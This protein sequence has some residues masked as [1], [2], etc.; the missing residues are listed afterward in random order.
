MADVTIVIPVGPGH[1]DLANRAISSAQGQTVPVE[2]L[3]VEDNAGRGPGWARNRGLAET[4]TKWVVFL[5]ADDYLEPNAI[6]RL[7]AMAA[8]HPGRYVYSDAWMGDAVREAPETGQA[9]CKGTWH[10]VTALLPAQ[11]VKWVGGFD[12]TLPGGED[13]E[14]YVKL[15][16]SGLCGVRVPEPLVH[17]TPAGQRSQAFRNGPRYSETMRRIYERWSGKMACCGN[18]DTQLN[19]AEGDRQPGDVL[20]QTLWMGNRP[21]RGIASGR[22]YGRTG[23]GKL[24]WMDPRDIE[25]QPHLFRRVENADGVPEQ[26]NAPRSSPPALPQFMRE[27][28]RKIPVAHGIDQIGAAIFGTRVASQKPQHYRPMRPVEQVDV[29]D[30]IRM[31]LE[32]LE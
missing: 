26:L 3:V 9:W 28:A 32:A 6:E 10:V 20:A 21:A 31:G 4:Q 14:L 2:V 18:N 5:D 30:I 19:T 27:Q 25:A 23:N 15:G 17:Y 16:A 1:R 24:L 13:T 8:K 29:S 7:L 12:E 11:R 22:H